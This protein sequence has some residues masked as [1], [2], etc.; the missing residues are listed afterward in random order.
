MAYKRIA[1]VLP[2]RVVK[3]FQ[4]QLS[5]FELGVED[6]RLIGFIFAFG[7]L[8]SIGLALNVSIFF[9]VPIL[10]AFLGFFLLFTGGIYL[11]LS[12]V[13][14]SKGKFVEKILPDA[15]QLIA[16]NIKAG[17][18]TERALFVSARPEFGPLSVEL[19]QASKGI[20]S[21]ERVEKSL[22]KL[23][24][25]IRSGLLDKTMWLISKGIT[26]GGQ[27]ADLLS[28][29]SDDLRQQN[30]VK[31][32]IKANISIYVLL[33]FFSAAIG[34][35]LL[36]GISSFIV[37]VLTTQKEAFAMDTSNI[38]MGEG[39]GSQLISTEAIAITTDFIVMFIV[40][41]II[42]SSVFAS[43]TIGIINTGK[44]KNGLKMIPVT[45]IVALIVFLIVRTAL[46]VMF[47]ELVGG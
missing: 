25:K 5:Y 39:I 19:K 6:S 8:L 1:S 38:Q 27:I 41:I 46:L 2:K 43:L 36:F 10:I 23:A 20:L 24:K 17:L 29:L 33:I 47:G 11:W 22:L 12:V 16:S 45:I 14:E 44:E 4:K 32:E 37:Q 35:P 9:E 40:I 18:T 28:Q 3:G 13:S 31:E 15:L 30:S 26:S 34:G 42:V 7:L 21:G